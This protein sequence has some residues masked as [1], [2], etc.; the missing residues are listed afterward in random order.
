MRDSNTVDEVLQA[1]STCN[2]HIVLLSAASIQSLP[3]AVKLAAA[4][5]KTYPQT[6]IAFE[7]RAAL[8]ARES[9]NMH[10]D[11]VVSGFEKGHQTLLNLV[12]KQA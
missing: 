4:I 6:R 7:G 12:N 9:L 2:P 8:L 5:R 3:P 11:A 1:A 10:G